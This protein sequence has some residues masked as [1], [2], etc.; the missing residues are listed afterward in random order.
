ML[1]ASL[2]M[3]ALGQLRSNVHRVIAA[4]NMRQLGVAVA[5]YSDDYAGSLPYS[6]LLESGTPEELMAAHVGTTPNAWDG[7]GLLYQQGY[8]RAA[9]VFYAPSHRGNHPF[10]RYE[11]EW[12]DPGGTVRIYTNFHYAGHE[13]WVNGR[14]RSLRNGEDLVV[15]SD[16]LRTRDD[17]NHR[18]GINLLHGDLTVRWHLDRARIFE[19]LP[20]AG[21]NG[22]PLTT[23]HFDQIWSELTPDPVIDPEAP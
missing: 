7:L 21:A 16:G 12:V 11:Q 5:M 9:E 17:L 4:S 15:L 18:N 13:N 3:P 8:C 23:E 19:M 1:L 10:S 2:L 6:R 20:P 14:A 22:D